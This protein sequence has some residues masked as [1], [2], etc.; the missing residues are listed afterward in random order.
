[1]GSVAGSR[2]IGAVSGVVLVGIG[3]AGAYR[4]IARHS[5]ALLF[6]TLI[7]GTFGILLALLELS[8]R[9]RH[10]PREVTSRIVFFTG[11]AASIGGQL[12][13]RS[14]SGSAGALGSIMGFLLGFTTA[15]S[16]GSANRLEA[17]R[18]GGGSREP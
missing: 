6:A 17:R 1:M 13:F 9:R 2:A 11:L 4:A 8:Y 16:F 3:I 10:A 12:L 7:G 14:S 15:G 18:S 5:D